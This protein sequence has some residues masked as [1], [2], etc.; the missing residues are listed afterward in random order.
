MASRRNQH[1]ANCIG[2]ISFL[3]TR[4]AN[5]RLHRKTAWIRATLHALS[6]IWAES[7]TRIFV[8]ARIRRRLV[9][10]NRAADAA[11][12]MAAVD[13][14]DGWLRFPSARYELMLRTC[15]DH[16][17]ATRPSLSVWRTAKR[18][19]AS[20][21]TM[22]LGVPYALTPRQLPEEQFATT[23]VREWLRVL[24]VGMRCDMSAVNCAREIVCSFCC[25]WSV[26]GQSNN[27][28]WDWLL[29]CKVSFHT[30]LPTGRGKF[31]AD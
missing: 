22:R 12:C 14:V 4:Q 26:R 11:C 18:K 16:L 10:D 8:E 27:M 24:M 23:P 28:W 2:T 21:N 19:H 13:C 3:Y 5:K 1:C 6:R 15:D 31:S 17:S 29:L 30:L 20:L 25:Q 7:E 9:D